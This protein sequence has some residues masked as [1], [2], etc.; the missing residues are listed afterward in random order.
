MRPLIPTPS[1]TLATVAVTAE[2]EVVI[3]ADA[4]EI[5]AD[6]EAALAVTAEATVEIAAE[7]E[8]LAK[9]EAT[10]DRAKSAQPESM[11][12]RSRSEPPLEWKTTPLPPSRIASPRRKQPKT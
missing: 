10:A 3:E 11:T 7:T 12:L 2:V 5:A 9:S 1:R 4:I 8:V 6:A